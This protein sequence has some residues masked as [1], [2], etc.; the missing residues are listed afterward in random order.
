VEYTEVVSSTA[1]IKSATS[2]QQEGVKIVT[3]VQ[4]GQL[5]NCGLIPGRGMGHFKAK[6]P[7]ELWDPIQPPT[8]HVS[9]DLSLKKSRWGIK[10]ITHLH[11][12][13][14]F[15]MHGVIPPPPHLNGTF[16]DNILTS[17]KN[18]NHNYKYLC[19]RFNYGGNATGCSGV[20]AG[21]RAG[22]VSGNEYRKSKGGKLKR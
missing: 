14:K 1:S 15:R 6:H 2:T 22:F 18:Q 19:S 20:V 8:Q 13:P 11:T 5:R 4:A 7:V 16:R 3:R 12:V 10:P 9:G 21:K 17:N